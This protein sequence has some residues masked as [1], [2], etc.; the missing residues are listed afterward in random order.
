MYAFDGAARG[1]VLNSLR[2]NDKLSC[3]AERRG[4]RGQATGSSRAHCNYA[5]NSSAMLGEQLLLMWQPFVHLFVSRMAKKAF[6]LG[7]FFRRGPSSYSCTRLSRPMAA[8]QLYFPYCIFHLSAIDRNLA[9][10]CSLMKRIACLY[11]LYLY[12]VWLCRF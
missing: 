2:P 7:R 10:P 8:I 5:V 3:R 11:L 1:F 6:L 9:Y 12:P 4:T